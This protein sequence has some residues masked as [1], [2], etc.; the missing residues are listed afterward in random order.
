MEFLGFSDIDDWDNLDPAAFIEMN[1]ASNDVN[2]R[3]D[4]KDN[5]SYCTETELNHQTNP[6]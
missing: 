1:F 3:H 4:N 5:L 2:E 6:L